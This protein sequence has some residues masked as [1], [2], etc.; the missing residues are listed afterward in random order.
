MAKRIKEIDNL[1]ITGYEELPTPGALKDELALKGDAL[2]TVKRGHRQ[3]K[4]ILNRED[5][6]LI[7][8]VGPC[9]IHNPEEAIEYAKLLKPLADELADELLILM[10]VYFEK[11]RTSVG[12]E[13]LIYDPHLDGSH[14]IDHGIRIG[15]KLMLDIAEVGLPIA[16]EALDLIS[17]QYLQ[18]LV[19][20]TAI[21]ARTTES[22]THRKL[23]SGISSAIGFKNNVEGELMVAINAIR[24]A[25]ANHSFI[26]VTEEGK[27]AVFRTEG[28]PHCHIILRGG[29]SPNYDRES[30]RRCEEE[31]RRAGHE[32]NIMIDCSHGNSQ[33]NHDKQIEVLNEVAHQINAG[34]DSI[35]GVMIESNLEE[36]NQP[37]P[38]DL[39]EIRHGVSVT[40]ACIS[41]ETTENILRKFA[42]DVSS[43][44]KARSA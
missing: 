37:I 40:D 3:V 10:R 27:V 32:E 39:E 24:S 23:A 1:H 13:G 25:S 2:K 4:S 17:P 26:S 14:R 21:G 5:P 9:S 16:I 34:N 29:K 33:K 31:L 12:W 15:R 44:L 20:W 18:D 38:D 43:S 19:S 8:V 28:N 22:P 30:V 42:A 11:P 35:I 41:W 7:V 36:G 6:R